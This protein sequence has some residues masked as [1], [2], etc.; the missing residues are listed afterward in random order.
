LDLK[1]I[2]RLSGRVAF[3]LGLVACQSSSPKY[4]QATDLPKDLRLGDLVFVRGTA[5]VS[6]LIA[7]QDTAGRGLSHVGIVVG[8]E[9]V[10]MAH[11]LGN[12]GQ[13]RAR[14]ESLDSFLVGARVEPWLV[15]RPVDSAVGPRAVKSVLALVQQGI[16]YDYAFDPLDSTKL[17]CTELPWLGYEQAL[18]PGSLDLRMNWMGKSWIG[19]GTFIH[20][21]HFRRVSGMWPE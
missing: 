19:L 1:L 13:D 18:S 12:R 6:D 21:K 20:S 11:I 8:L 3:C 7:Q 15:L 10:R 4:L 9:P 2:G 5:M 14:V 17:Y 16:T